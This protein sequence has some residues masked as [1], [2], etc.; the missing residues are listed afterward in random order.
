MARK[1][2][3]RTLLLAAW[4]TWG[5]A[6]QD[7]AVQDLEEVIHVDGCV[8]MKVVHST[9]QNVFGKRAVQFNLANRSDVA[10]YAK[11]EDIVLVP[12]AA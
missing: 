12:L 6:A 11:R 7:L 8:H 9:N 2:I 1:S 10:Y 3:M 5:V 4:A